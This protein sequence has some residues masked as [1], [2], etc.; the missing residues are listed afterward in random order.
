[1]NGTRNRRSAN[2]RNRYQAELDKAGRSSSLPTSTTG[3]RR[4]NGLRFRHSGTFGHR[5]FRGRL[6]ER[7]TGRPMGRGTPERRVG[8]P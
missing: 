4:S 7:L 1:M 6:A 5:S 3:N 2:Q 8:S